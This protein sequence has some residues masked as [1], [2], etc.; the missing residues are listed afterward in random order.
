IRL[1]DDLLEKRRAS[2]TLGWRY[3]VRSAAPAPG[4]EEDLSSTQLAALAL[5]AADRCGIPTSSDVW[6]DLIAFAMRQQEKDGPAH[7]RAVVLRPKS[8]GGATVETPRAVNDRAR[9]F[10]YILSDTLAPDEG[11]ATG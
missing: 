1:R 2:K 11:R 6:N 3:Q 10:A 8:A 4:G 9:G 5:L 7:P